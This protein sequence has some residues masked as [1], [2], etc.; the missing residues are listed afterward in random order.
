MLII[1]VGTMQKN[2]NSISISKKI[3]KSNIN[4]KYYQKQK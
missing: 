1:I 4:K 3:K 2:S